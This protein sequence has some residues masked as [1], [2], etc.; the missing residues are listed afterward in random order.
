MLQVEK[1]DDDVTTLQVN[2]RELTVTQCSGRLLD[3]SSPALCQIP[4][5]ATVLPPSQCNNFRLLPRN[6]ELSPA[7][8]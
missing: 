4:V 3:E 6:G 8:D 2:R 7:G 5:G 1:I